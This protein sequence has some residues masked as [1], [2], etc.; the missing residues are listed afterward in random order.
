LVSRA[1]VRPCGR[2]AVQ[3]SSDARSEWRTRDEASESIRFRGL[4]YRGAARAREPWAAAAAASFFLFLPVARSTRPPFHL[5]RRGLN[6][7]RP[8]DRRATSPLH[9]PLSSEE[10]SVCVVFCISISTRR[11]LCPRPVSRRT[12]SPARRTSS[13]APQSPFIYRRGRGHPP[14][15]AEKG[16]PALSLA[17]GAFLSRP[18]GW[19]LAPGGEITRARASGDAH[20]RA[21]ATAR[22][23]AQPVRRTQVHRCTA[24]PLLTF[25]RPRAH[26][27]TFTCSLP[28]SSPFFLPPRACNP[29]RALLSSGCGRDSRRRLRPAG[30]QHA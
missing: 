20:H 6:V 28:P 13:G 29:P 18:S 7:P 19:P 25:S 26:T 22:S 10:Q 23:L 12:L 2:A 30:Q 3:L 1:A 11:G 16:A 4:P 8:P 17:P 9:S 15:F 21:A 24:A 5:L 14:V 27:Q